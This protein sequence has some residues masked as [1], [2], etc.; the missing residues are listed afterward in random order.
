MGRD[1]G[2]DVFL[3][4]ARSD[5]AAAAELNGWLRGQDLR[6]F[7]DRS[8]LRPGLR[9]I[10]ALEDAIGRSGAVAILVGRHGI[11]NTQQYE[12]ELA[13]VRQTRDDGFPVIPVL[14]P[15]CEN[16]PT[17]FLQLLTWIDLSRGDSVVQQTD[18]LEAL[19][20]AIRL[21]P[22]QSSPIRALICPYRGLEPFREEDAAF[23][24]GRE[25]AIRDL[26]ARVQLHTFVAV[27]GP[28]GS[29][30]SSLVFAGLLPALRQQS[31]TTMW[32]VL[33]FR[34][35]AS[36]LRALAAAFGTVPENAGPAAIDTY[37]E[38]EA[39][40]Y[41]AGDAD[42]LARIVNHR[43]DA[44][45]EKPDRLLIYI[46]QWEEL[47]AM[48]PAAEE[49]ER[50]LQHS[51]DV[52]RFIALLVAATSSQ[53]LRATVVLTVRADFYAP[54]IRQTLL[55][56]LLPRQQVNI[57]PMGSDDL[58]SA[59][60]TPAK[61][62]GLSFVPPALVD[63]ILND[64]GTEEGRLPLLQF[65]LKE[66]WEKR[67]GDRL[68]AEAYME[69]GGVTGAI[70]KTAERAYAAL[71][72]AQQEAARRLFL[73]L[74]TPGEGQEDT[75]ARSAIP[76]DP[77]Q[78][79]II[80][81]F[82]NPRTRLLVTGYDTLPGPA[83][84]GSEVRATVEVA[85]EEL[86]RRWPTLRAWVDGNREKLRARATI[87]RAKAEW[88]EAGKN[89]EFLLPSGIQL[90]RG[91]ALLENPGDVPVDDIR[92]YVD[93][94]INKE[95]LHLAAEREDALADQRRISEAERQAKEA[96]EEAAR[97]SEAARAAAEVA[98]RKLRN[99]L[100]QIASAA[101]IA[102][103][104]FAVS[105]YEG[106]LASQNAT[107][108]EAQALET[109]HQLDRA[110]QALAAGILNDL[111]LSRDQRLTA[112]QR[113]ALWK[114]SAV[115]EAVKRNFISAL[116]ASP[117]D[118]ARI[119]AGFR[120]V[121]RSV[122]LQRP[123]PAEAEK[124]FISAVEAPERTTHD[125]KMVR[126]SSIELRALAAKLNEAQAQQ[127][128]AEVLQ[129]IGQTTNPFAFEVLAQTIEALPAKLTE[130][131]AQQAL[132]PVLRQIGQTTYPGALQA[133]AEAIQALPATLIDA[134]V[135]Q[136]L[137]PLMEQIG[138][139]TLYVDAPQVLAQ[140]FQAL[141]A[142]L[143]EAQAEQAL[144]PLLR[145]IGTTSDSFRLEKL[146]DAIQALA[147][148]LTEAQAQQALDPVLRKIGQTTYPGAA[149]ALAQA[150]QALAP[151][152]TEA[153]AQQALPLLL[154]QIGETTDPY[155]L[156]ALTRAIQALAPKLT[157]A[158]AQ[159]AFPLLLKRI[160]QAA[161][162]NAFRAL[163]PALQALAAKLTE[164]QAQ[165]ALAQLLQQIGQTTNPDALQALAQ[166]MQALRAKV[167]EAQAQQA[168][169]PLLRQFGQTSNPDALR[170]L[171]QA[172][173]ALPA[174]LTEAQAQQALDPL[175][176]QIGQT[177]NP[178]AP[179]LLAQ[180][181][182]A[183]AA[184]VTAAQAQ[185]ALP[186]MLKQIGQTTYS[187]ALQA[188]AQALQALAPKL[189]QGQ[190]QQAV[191]VAKL[192]LA[193]AAT[194]DEAVD[195]ARAL[196]ALLPHATDGDGTTDLLAALV[197]PTAAGPAT[198]VL[199]DALR[200]RHSDAPVKDVGT[201]ASFAWVMKKFPDVL[202]PPI[203]PPPPQPTAISGLKCPPAETEAPINFAGGAAPDT[204]DAT[205]R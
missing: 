91:R 161:Y 35:G 33:S 176:R 186:A 53:K 23:F 154:K 173:E 110:N 15:G 113:N 55:S 164:A 2:F 97:Q 98:R 131:Q 125:A 71:T 26:A 129:Q 185:Q 138:D 172:I 203:C 22:V 168:L 147:P 187:E 70:Q 47:Y 101:L 136:A 197:Y 121:F 149:Q 116:S 108:A 151:K 8:E 194:E 153:Q 9:W 115:D 68:T 90:E 205:A 4:Y 104:A 117:E 181:L 165:Q 123:S 143:T 120:E 69:V 192:S 142:K 109:Q 82:S 135:Q 96:A 180:A 3:S 196:V 193:W 27:V 84:T 106:N 202:L 58:R 74:V 46:D 83:E 85:H 67:E 200:V 139:E 198:E 36:P 128:L 144:E 34:P 191:T 86:I 137:T 12:R 93:L 102:L 81:L 7:F 50:R 195:W 112:R 57:P 75:R 170:L 100:V 72:P 39:A 28:S 52:E 49:A 146:A 174:W 10:P 66:T 54:L 124:L 42:K 92:A 179:R 29:G 21:H 107:K 126:S 79:D 60:E 201:A 118:M 6:T 88:E 127:A 63:Q 87:L 145:Q 40:A 103:L 30:K 169:A 19:C 177:S 140:A 56:T 5:G 167:T 99:R 38:N 141:A 73:R 13:L 190:A 76:D 43:L 199:F 134:Q 16:P 157:E 171:A 18:R 59:I 184:K 14:M 48:A 158:Q 178:D 41:R 175:L 189:A 111:D 62:A 24:C 148:K 132:D 156:Q 45:P 159:Q 31:E 64:T 1:G 94:S 182:Q 114:L 89:D 152:L 133:L 17:G 122:G 155:T 204:K 25:D 183:L 95:K 119:A 160:G 105:V 130:A 61:K 166:A 65:A 162:R 80:N 188:L 78:R 37:L 51:S 44:A 11:G 163:A 77:Q 32:D 150:L 20:A